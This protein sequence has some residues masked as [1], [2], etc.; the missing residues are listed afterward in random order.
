MSDV[1]ADLD[2]KLAQLKTDLQPLVQAEAA[3]LAEAA[4]KT[5]ARVG[6]DMQIAAAEAARVAARLALLGEQAVPKAEADVKAAV[7]SPWG[8][9][10]VIGIVV[11]AVLAA[12]VGAA[13]VGW[14]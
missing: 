13:R 8:K 9:R 12:V 6:H 10:I 7:E 4:T 5:A 3:A 2:A 14:L 11:A 1:L